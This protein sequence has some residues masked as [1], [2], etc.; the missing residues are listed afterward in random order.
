MKPV[1]QIEEGATVMVEV[2]MRK[3]ERERER[4][5]DRHTDNVKIKNER[6]YT[7]QEILY[8]TDKSFSPLKS[9][10]NLKTFCQVKVFCPG[11]SSRAS[12]A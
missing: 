4:Q 5:T 8:I 9:L 12:A 3:T 6:K 7:F 10:H 2:C 1:L 11:L